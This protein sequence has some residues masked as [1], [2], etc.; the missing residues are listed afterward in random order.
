[1]ESVEA[2]APYHLSA[3]EKKRVAIAGVLAMA[4]EILVLED[5]RELRSLLVR[6]LRE[7]GFHVTS[8]GS[9]AELLEL[10]VLVTRAAD[11]I[12]AEQGK[13]VAAICH[14]PWLLVEAGEASS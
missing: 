10:R 8:A 13:V 6:G 5:D 12:V 7:E 3:G 11:A 4:P 9:A 1:M 14:A 2:K